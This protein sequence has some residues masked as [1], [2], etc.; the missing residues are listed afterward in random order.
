M[1]VNSTIS[2]S[3]AASTQQDAA[4]RDADFMSLMLAE[5]SNQDPFNPTET[6]KMVEGMQQLQELANSRYDKFRNDIR[7]AQDLM[8]SE[9]SVSQANLTADEATRL[10]EQ[11]LDPDVGF[12]SVTGVA[13][14]FRV[15][16]EQ[17]WVQVDGKDY[18]L[19]NV[20]SISPNSGSGDALGSWADRILGRE[21]SWFDE[22][23]SDFRSGIAERLS[24]RDGQIVA[25]VGDETVNVDDI[26]KALASLRLRQQLRN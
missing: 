21:V 7:W 11:G 9:V 1:Q 26:S 12:A 15:V 5:V 23:T 19:D 10:R 4:M 8:G 24:L 20:R 3:Q 25:H 2:A 13:Q 17:V 18:Q 14:G 16:D 22:E 6:S